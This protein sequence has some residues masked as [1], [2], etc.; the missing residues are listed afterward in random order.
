MKICGPDGGKV[1]IFFFATDIKFKLAR[2]FPLIAPPGGALGVGDVKAAPPPALPRLL[3][4]A[5]DWAAVEGAAA[6]FDFLAPVETAGFSGTGAGAGAFS[7]SGGATFSS[8]GGSGGGGSDA[9]GGSSGAL[10][11]AGGL[12]SWQIKLTDYK[13]FG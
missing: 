7:G 6:L 4:S 5:S 13:L 2:S 10:S 9:A 12:A 11:G 3:D 8:L 1:Y